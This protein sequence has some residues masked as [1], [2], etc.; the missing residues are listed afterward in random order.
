MRPPYDDNRH[1]PSRP[2]RAR[3]RGRWQATA[4][5]AD[6]DTR[7][8]VVMGAGLAFFAGLAVLATVL[9]A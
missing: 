8:A 9:P 3:H 2:H 6:P 1:S 7:M 4:R 5:R